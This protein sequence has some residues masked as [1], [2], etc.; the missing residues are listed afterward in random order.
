[1]IETFNLSRRS[2]FLGI[3]C[4]PAIVR[5]SSLMPVKAYA[6]QAWGNLGPFRQL[7]PAEIMEDLRSGYESLMREIRYNHIAVTRYGQGWLLPEN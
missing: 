6:D 2:A 7:T 3:I 5:A 4:A 1:M